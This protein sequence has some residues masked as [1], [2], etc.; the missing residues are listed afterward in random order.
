MQLLY[1]LEGNMH[2]RSACQILKIEC[3]RRRLTVSAL[4]TPPG[5]LCPLRSSVFRAWLLENFLSRV[6]FDACEILF[7]FASPI[8]EFTGPTGSS[9]VQKVL[10]QLRRIARGL[11]VAVEVVMV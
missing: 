1:Q 2:L 4:G 10:K 6:L 3:A 7:E 9:P 5:L 8:F 11:R